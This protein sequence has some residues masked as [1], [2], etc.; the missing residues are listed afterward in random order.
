MEMYEKFTIK[1]W[2]NKQMKRNFI[3]KRDI[4]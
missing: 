3:S 2:Q 1:K 4:L